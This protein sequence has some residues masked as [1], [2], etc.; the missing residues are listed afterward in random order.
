MA[1]RIYALNPGEISTSV[2]ENVGPTGTSAGIALIIDAAV[3]ITGPGGGATEPSKADVLRAL[4]EIKA[5]LIRD[6]TWPPA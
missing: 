4:E 3:T 1:T 6:N 5:Y 2:R